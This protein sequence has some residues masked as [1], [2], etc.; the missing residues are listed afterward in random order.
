M[1]RSPSASFPRRSS[2]S[3]RHC[4]WTL[5]TPRSAF[6]WNRRRRLSTR[7]GAPSNCLAEAQQQLKRQDLTSR[8]AARRRRSARIRKIRKPGQLL[9]AINLDI[10]K[11]DQRGRWKK[12]LPRRRAA[13]PLEITM[14]RCRC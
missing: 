14:R 13:R 10:E 11:R 6:A 2:Y 7:A 3:N 5:A 12:I 4:G 9:E 8:I 1:N